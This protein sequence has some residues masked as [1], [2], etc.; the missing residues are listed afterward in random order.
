MPTLPA[1]SLRQFAAALLQAGP[2]PPDEAQIVADSLV[3]ANLRGHDSHGVMRIPF[4]LAQVEKRE[5][6]PGA[7]FRVL[8][9]TGSILVADGNW[10][11]GQVQAGRLTDRLIEKAIGTPSS[12]VGGESQTVG[13]DS[14]VGGE[15]LRRQNGAG[16]A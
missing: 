14:T 12:T 13:G 16:L 4:Y 1:D 10:G 15:S 5:A 11:F 9:E 3:A 7:E 8:K 6:V 2:A